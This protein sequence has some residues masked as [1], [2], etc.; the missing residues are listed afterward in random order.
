MISMILGL[1]IIG[2]VIGVMMS[3]RRSYSTNTGLGQVQESARTAFE[4]LAHDIRQADGNGCGNIARTANVLTAGAL[5]WQNWFGVRGYNS[6]QAD[7]AVAIG[8]A[9]G[10]RVAG[11]DAVHVESIDGTTLSIA[12][13]DAAARQ[14]DINV[15]ASDFVAGDI[16]LVC[17]FD[18]TTIFQASASNPGPGVVSVFHDN[19]IGVPG[20]CSQG[21]GF[22][23]DCGSV[24]GNVYTFPRNSQIGRLVVT[25]WYI[26]NNGRAGEGGRS[27]FR[28]RMGVGGGVVT[29][30]VVAGVV[31]MQLQFRAT[32]DNNIIADASLVPDWTIVSS[33]LVRITSRSSDINVSTDSTVNNGRVERTFNYLITLRNRLP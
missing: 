24:A 9:V 7:P 28:R 6:T 20:N 12:Q 21:L 18:H 33:I 13:H 25:D 19:G 31:D 4:L 32:N 8:G 10:E 11:T 15:A 5:W 1:L 16:M 29:E 23:T 3:N 2:A 14:L 17:D 26:G 30:E 27:L 22:P